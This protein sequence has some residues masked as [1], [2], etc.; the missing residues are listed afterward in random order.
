MQVIPA[1][2]MGL[3]RIL[4]ILLYIKNYTVH[5]K[6]RGNLIR[7]TQER[8]NDLGYDAG[9]ADGYAESP[10]MNGIARFQ[11]AYGLGV[12]YL[13]GTDWYYMIES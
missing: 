11:N 13:G 1:E 2:Q 7:W 3:Q 5:E 10:T 9:Y 6:D 4:S 8:L 12:G